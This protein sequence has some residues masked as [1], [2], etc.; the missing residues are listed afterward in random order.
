PGRERPGLWR[1]LGAFL[2]S[3]PTG[4]NRMIFGDAYRTFD[5]DRQ[6]V[7][8][9]Q[10]FA[11]VGV[12]YDRTPVEQSGDETAG[13]AHAGLRLAFGL[14]DERGFPVRHPFDHFDLA[15]TVA[16]TERES[17]FGALF[18]RGMLA[19]TR[20]EG[21]WRGLWGLT[22][23][24]D[25]VAPR[26]F[27]VGTVGLGISTTGQLGTRGEVALQGTALLGAGFGNA[28]AITQPIGGRDYHSG[29]AAQVVLEARLLLGDTAA[30]GAELRQY[31]VAGAVETRGFEE[32]TY[33][34]LSGLVRIAGP[35]AV[36][37]ERLAT[38]RRAAYGDGPDIHQRSTALSIS[39]VM[40]TDPWFGA[41]RP[42]PE[43]EVD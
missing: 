16:A 34:T 5:F 28:G 41:Y 29:P 6:P 31:L 7:T 43:V 13:T 27:R 11:G 12:A 3:P 33:L 8:Y 37:V 42:R 22:G 20:I 38:R 21:S 10:A 17:P 32:M 24:F 40:V 9:L 15:F 1:G 25:Y 4:V 2:L 36:S 26:V 35:H 19:G 30:I 18:I 39:Y 23:V 14:P